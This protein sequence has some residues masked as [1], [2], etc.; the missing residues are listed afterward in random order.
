MVQDKWGE[1]DL[2]VPYHPFNIDATINGAYIAMGL[3]YGENDMEKTIDIAIRCGQDT[4]CN[5]ANAAAVLGI[6]QGY[7]AIDESLHRTSL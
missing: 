4:D 5:A 3:L 7:E 6:I 2:C 1:S